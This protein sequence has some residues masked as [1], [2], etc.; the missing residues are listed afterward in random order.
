MQ[1]ENKARFLDRLRIPYLSK[2]Y[3]ARFVQAIYMFINGM[4]T[5]GILALIAM[6]F[7]MPVVFPSLGPTAV[8]LFTAP[9]QTSSIPRN[10]L[11]GHAIGILCGYVS[12]RLFGLTG[13]GSVLSEGVLLSRVFAAGL[14]LGATGALMALFKTPHPPAG[15]TTLIIALGFITQPYQLLV[16]E[17]A[18]A[19]LLLQ[20][21]I[22]NKAA[23]VDTSPENRNEFG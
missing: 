10:V 20:A 15:A 4:I 2:H 11:V 12:L 9:Q 13:H 1:L 5:I 19:V 6:V 3:P 16:I 8:L 17:I 22:I 23:G 21:M 14:S 7:H 18:V